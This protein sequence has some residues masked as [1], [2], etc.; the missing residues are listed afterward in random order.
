MVHPHEL[1]VVIPATLR[2]GQREGSSGQDPAV[3]LSEA[4]HFVLVADVGVKIC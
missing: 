2:C 1:T 3:A 4:E